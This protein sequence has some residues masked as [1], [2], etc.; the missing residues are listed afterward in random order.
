MKHWKV[1]LKLIIASLLVKF[2]YLLLNAFITGN[3]SSISLDSYI[4]LIKRN[5]SWWYERVV[6]DGYP[7]IREK[8][9]I[10]SVI[11]GVWT[12]TQWAFF[13]F[14]PAMNR[15][16]MKLFNTD[17]NHSAFFLSLLFSFLSLI[18][19]YYFALQQLKDTKKAFFSSMVFLLF[20]FHYYFSMMYTEAVFFTFM[21]FSFLALENKKYGWFA[22]LIVPLVLTRVNGL[23][24]LIPLYMYHLEKENILSKK[25]LYIK[26]IFTKHNI[27]MS[28]MFLS[29]VIAFGL[30]CLYQKEKT[31]FFFAFNVAQAGWGRET[32]F[33][34]KALFRHSNFM[35]IFNSI[36][37][38]LTAIIAV[39]AWKK[40]PLSL[41]IW[42]WLSLLIP[43]SSGSVVSV[44]RF[45]SVLF[46]ITIFI[47]EWLYSRKY[48]YITLILLFVFQ[49]WTF[50]FWI[51]GSSFAY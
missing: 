29:A 35:T 41:N 5:D 3:A 49:L 46:P 36:Y 18:G 20:P 6:T 7:E 33:P 12:Q 8:D 51:S 47:G 37:I 34:L 30:Y 43:L 50:Y 45:I 13:P 27:K 19:F 2:A 15:I 4:G 14:Y 10:G 1:I 26:E 23:I 28:C 42:I 21:I 24:V 22:V 40:Y 31:G 39:F 9:S 32:V 17:F 16:V 48:H 11:D 44:P 25:H 38:I